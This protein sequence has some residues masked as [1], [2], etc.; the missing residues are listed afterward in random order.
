MQSSSL[1][2]RHAPEDPSLSAIGDYDDYGGDVPSSPLPFQ[3]T[4]LELSIP[5]DPPFLDLLLQPTITS[6]FLDPTFIKPSHAPSLVKIAPQLAILDLAAW[7]DVDDLAPLFPASH[8]LSL[9]SCDIASALFILPVLPASL[10]ELHLEGEYEGRTEA[11]EVDRLSEI[12]RS[13]TVALSGLRRL[14][15]DGAEKSRQETKCVRELLALC[16]SRRI[17]LE[18]LEDFESEEG[19]DED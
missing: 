5:P 8:L 14:V 6:L 17:V 3:L 18:N 7:L 10:E 15:I 12:L 11:R 1:I 13:N 2:P 9:L 16:Q 19:S 4:R